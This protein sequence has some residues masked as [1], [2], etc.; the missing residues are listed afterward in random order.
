MYVCPY[1]G[2]GL[3]SIVVPT[4]M[5]SLIR[6]R[7]SDLYKTTFTQ[8]EKPFYLQPCQASNY[9]HTRSAVITLVSALT[10]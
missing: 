6:K 8:D 3:L 9:R 10:A 4:R 7:L 2:G 5:A 1:K